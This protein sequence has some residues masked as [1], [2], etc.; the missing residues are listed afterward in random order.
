MKD[1]KNLYTFFYDESEH[2]RKI[3]H[4][5][6]NSA[7]YSNNFITVI[8]GYSD[9]SIEEVENLY[10]DLKEKYSHRLVKNEFKSTSL[11]LQ[12]GFASA[13][14]DSL[15]FLSDLLDIVNTETRICYSVMNK[16][17]F[18][19]NQVFSGNTR[20]DSFLFKVDM[21]KL[22]YSISKLIS[23][24]KPKN[25]IKA[26]YEE[27]EVVDEIKKFSFQR[28]KANKTNEKLKQTE[29]D[30]L[31]VLIVVLNGYDKNFEVDWNYTLPFKDFKNYL[32]S[33]EIENYQLIIDKEG[34][35]GEESR[36][37]MSAKAMRIKN[38]KEKDS[39]EMFGI[40]LADLLAGIISKFIKRLDEDTHYL[41][42]KEATTKKLVSEKWFKIEENQFNLYKKF[43]LTLTAASNYK[44]I[45]AFHGVYADGLIRFLSLLEYFNSY[46]NYQNYKE[47]ELKNH[48]EYYNTCSVGN[49][50][51]YFDSQF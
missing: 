27:G 41:D 43:S 19:V 24:Y 40:Q 32:K 29:N 20:Y 48:C 11:K 8:L 31:K 3:N 10:S 37:L 47:V 38:V 51:Q 22:R 30:M 2:S 9:D 7:N 13:R 17:E 14:A 16:I 25:I 21:N 12:Y 46:K 35:E 5:T 1:E 44:S 33:N 15:T 28:L 4:K 50:Q 26:I 18:V 6:V 36:T 39:V 42:L 49:L 45:K 34:R 23:T